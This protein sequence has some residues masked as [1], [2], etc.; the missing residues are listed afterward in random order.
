MAQ[1]LFGQSVK[2]ETL[3]TGHLEDM[4]KKTGHSHGDLA[5]GLRRAASS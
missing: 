1:V 4:W 2:T 5:A 3:T